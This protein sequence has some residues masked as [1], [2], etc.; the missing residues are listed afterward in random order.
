MRSKVLKYF[1]L[2]LFF[3]PL[4]RCFFTLEGDGIIEPPCT[5]S[6]VI[7]NFSQLQVYESGSLTYTQNMADATVEYLAGLCNADIIHFTFGNSANITRIRLEYLPDQS[8]YDQV[9]LFLAGGGGVY[10]TIDGSLDNFTEMI[11]GN[12]RIVPVRP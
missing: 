12:Y 4:W 8:A 3:M 9:V 2:L 1:L 11:G 7:V 6:S 5:H 10:L